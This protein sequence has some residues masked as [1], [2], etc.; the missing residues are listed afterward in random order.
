[1]SEMLCELL[2]CSCLVASA[3]LVCEDEY[4]DCQERA[5]KGECEGGIR[6]LSSVALA[7]LVNC[8]FSCKQRYKDALQLPK[9]VDELGGVEDTITDAFGVELDVCSMDD[10]MDRVMRLSVLRH[11]LTASRV[12]PWVPKFTDLGWEVTEIPKQLMGM[13]AVES[14]RG[15]MENEPCLTDLAAIN[16]QKM[17]ED[18]TECWTEHSQRMETLQLSEQMKTTLLTTLK[19]M[20]E[21]WSGVG[22]TGTSVYGVRRYK[23][24]AW[25]SEHV[26]QMA[27]HVISAILNVGQKGEPWPLFIMDHEDHMN[28]V[29]LEPGQMV[30]YESARLRHGRPKRFKGEFFDNVFVHFKPKDRKWYGLDVMKV[31]TLILN[32]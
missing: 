26:D 1:M 30:W 25:L 3:I 23:N 17:V 12:K 10:G 4:I 32:H 18:E 29:F 28:R 11:R 7:A 16:C 9:L 31:S 5:A 19:P 13:I 21:K 8:R 27:T 15:K 14:S 24:N 22:L 20:A 6:N 2:L